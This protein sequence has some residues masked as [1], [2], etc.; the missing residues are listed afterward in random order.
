V[1]IALL[2][3]AVQF[4]LRHRCAKALLLQIKQMDGCAQTKHSSPS[5]GVKAIERPLLQMKRKRF[6]QSTDKQREVAVQQGEN[7]IVRQSRAFTEEETLRELQLLGEAHRRAR[8][9]GP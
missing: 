8:T 7:G 9:A 4:T 6:P 5:T 1:F 3:L 2:P